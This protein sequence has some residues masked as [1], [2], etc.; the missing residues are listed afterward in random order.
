MTHLI[1]TV[2]V[3]YLEVIMMV[4]M[5]VPAMMMVMRMM[6]MTIMMKMMK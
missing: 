6:R 2:E 1:D 4:I 5:R 3:A